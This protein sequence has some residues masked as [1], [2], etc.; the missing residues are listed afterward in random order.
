MLYNA[1]ITIIGSFKKE[2]DK[3][4]F[5]LKAYIRHCVQVNIPADQK[6]LSLKP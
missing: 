1:Q 5:P 6:L 2:N 4:P 3:I